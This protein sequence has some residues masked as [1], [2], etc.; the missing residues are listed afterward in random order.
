MD[1]FGVGLR[2]D[3]IE[4]VMPGQPL[5]TDRSLAEAHLDGFFWKERFRIVT[6]QL[7]GPGIEAIGA[8]AAK[9]KIDS[10]A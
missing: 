2:D 1:I 9:H 5:F 6:L 10:C 4:R 7:W 3:T 8:A